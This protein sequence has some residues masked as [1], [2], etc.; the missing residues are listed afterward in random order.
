MQPSKITDEVVDEIGLQLV[1][2][3]PL[4]ADAEAIAYWMFCIAQSYLPTGNTAAIVPIWFHFCNFMS[5][6]EDRP[7]LN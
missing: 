6:A 4:D 1:Q 3:L 7:T 5:V 2:L